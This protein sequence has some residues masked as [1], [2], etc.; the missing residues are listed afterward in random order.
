MFNRTGTDKNRRSRRRKGKGGGKER[1]KNTETG[2]EK[3]REREGRKRGL[4][5]ANSLPPQLESSAATAETLQDDS[6]KGNAGPQT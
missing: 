1:K 6:S 2:R 4:A 5:E 3:G